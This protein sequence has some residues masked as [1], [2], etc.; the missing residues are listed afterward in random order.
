VTFENFDSSSLCKISHT[1]KGCMGLGVQL[2]CTHI[3][4]SFVINV[5]R[6]LG[7]TFKQALPALSSMLSGPSYSLLALPNKARILCLDSF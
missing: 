2:E 6:A 3:C 7:M 4:L 1:K 5:L